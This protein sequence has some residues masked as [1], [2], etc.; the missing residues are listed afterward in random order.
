MGRWGHRL[1]EGDLD[2][3]LASDVH[4]VVLARDGSEDIRF[5]H[6][7]DQS[8]L[9]DPSHTRE[10]YQSDEYRLEVEKIIVTI[11]N[12][13]DSGLGDKI[14]DKYRAKETELFGKYK[15]IIVGALMM[16]AGAEINKEHFQHLR[17]LVPQID[18]HHR[19]VLPIP[20]LGLRGPGRAQF[21]A[22]LDNY[23]T[24]TPRNFR[25][26]SC[27]HCGKVHADLGKTLKEC[28]GCKEAWYCGVIGLPEGPLEAAQA[29]LQ[30][31]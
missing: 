5:S 20:D 13:L 25:E 1:F 17:D 3:D 27:F 24:G 18:C 10:Y 7:L 12:R 28:G 29:H 19:Y 8:D 15:V 22:A 31:P 26:P 4:D 14:F 16:R 6:I 21:I 9:F 2:L 23:Q 30:A 11:R